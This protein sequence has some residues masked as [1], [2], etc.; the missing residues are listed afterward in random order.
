MSDIGAIVWKERKSMLRGRGT[1]GRVLLTLLSPLFIAVYLPWSIGT[2]W[3][4]EF[5]SLLVALPV[6]VILMGLLV[7]DSIA[8]ERERHT[9]A[10]LMASRLSERSIMAGKILVAGSVAWGL[11]IVALAVGAIVV[12]VTQWGEGI[13]FY[14]PSV[15]ITDLSISLSKAKLTSKLILRS[16]WP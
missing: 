4:T 14:R 7:P 1:R 9:L 13:H 10:T 16:V 8:G 2:D 15:I 12:N 6:P 3:F 5:P 11:S